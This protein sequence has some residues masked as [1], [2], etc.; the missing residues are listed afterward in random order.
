VRGVRVEHEVVAALR[1]GSDDRVG[2]RDRTHR[3]VAAREPLAADQ[4]VRT[5]APVVDGEAPAR[6]PVARHHLVGDQQHAVLAA[7][8]GE[9]WPV[10]VGRLDRARGRADDR[11][12][13]EGGHR[14]G[15][16]ALDDPFDLVGAGHVAGPRLETERTA[17][18]VARRRARRVEKVR[19]EAG[20]ALRVAPDRERRQRGPV[21]GEVAADHLPAPGAP[22]RHV[23][24]PRQPDGGVDRLGPAAREYDAREPASR[25]AGE[26][27]LEQPVD[28]CGAARGAEGRHHVAHL[29][30]AARIG[31]G[32]LAAPVA[33]VR[34]DGAA[35]GV[36]DAASIPRIQ[37]R[38]LGAVDLEGSTSRR[39]EAVAI[40][41]RAHAAML[42]PCGASCQDEA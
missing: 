22:G 4:D 20:L 30:E 21:V 29:F 31:L 6:T 19:L 12:R 35:R 13:D 32:D 18:A 8:V 17:Q 9:A 42:L 34:H 10:V 33:D 3:R 41:R 39:D 40:G 25:S 2:R 38:P 1:D 5:H 27:V 7:D 26:P 37:P 23:V 28:Q 11:L 15:T 14:V 24:L 16:L 36:E